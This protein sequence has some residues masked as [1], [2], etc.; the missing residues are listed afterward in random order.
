MSKRRVIPIL[1]IT[2]FLGSGKTSLLSSWLRSP[3]LSGATAIINELGEVGIDDRLVEFSSEA[4]LLL[5]NGCACCTAG[6]DL[7]ETLER[8]FWRQLHREIGP[9]SWVVIETTGIADPGPILQMLATHELLSTR[10]RVAGVI[11]TFDARNGPAQLRSNPECVHQLGLASTV[12]LTKLD[13]ATP[14][15]HHAAEQAV[16]KLAPNAALLGSA[17]ASLGIEQVI[18]SLDHRAGDALPASAGSH[19]HHSHHDEAQGHTHIAD[20][21]TGFLPTPTPLSPTLCRTVFEALDRSFGNGLL[22]LKGIAEIEG[23]PGLHSIQFAPGGEVDVQAV[24]YRSDPPQLGLTIIA[25]GVSASDIA[26]FLASRLAQPLA[27]A[28]LA[29]PGLVTVPPVLGRMTS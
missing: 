12:V 1:L 4:P 22:R 19:G 23:L 15:E 7:A 11:T 5:E 18:A 17:Q 26:R 21:S 8:L 27:V 16:R 3:A 25:R 24:P 13:L 6:E 28:E 2:G 10:Y 9:V 20:V 29:E 14:E